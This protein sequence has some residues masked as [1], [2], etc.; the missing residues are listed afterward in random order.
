MIFK[1]FPGKDMGKIYKSRK[2]CIQ[3]MKRSYCQEY[4]LDQ[5]L[6]PALTDFHRLKDLNNLIR[7]SEKRLKI[8]QQKVKGNTGEVAQERIIIKA[9][10]QLMDTL[11]NMIMFFETR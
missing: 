2:L 9:S 11:E 5:D 1:Y 6:R 10:K 8:L 4:G 7:A 3:L